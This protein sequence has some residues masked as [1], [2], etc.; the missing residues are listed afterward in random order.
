[1]K[2]QLAVK[3]QGHIPSFKNKKR[4]A[5]NRL[6]TDPKTRKWMDGCIQS[7]ESQLFLKSQTI[8]GVTSMVAPPLSLIVSSLPL[9][10]SRQWISELLIV[11]EVV[12][13]G[14]E[15]AEITIEKIL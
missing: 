7:F 6:I 11:S 2:I 3:N 12:P 5:R 8:A 4:I 14:E 1:M 13:R 15:G 10:D 9:D